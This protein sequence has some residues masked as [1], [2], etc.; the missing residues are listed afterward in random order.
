MNCIVCKGNL[1]N[2]TVKFTADLGKCVLIVKEVPAHVCSQCG[3]TSYSDEV[4]EQIEK[5]ASVA[6]DSQTEIFIA[7]F[8]QKQVA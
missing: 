6:R 2:K 4:F 3:E 8:Q 5:I 1:E 7:N